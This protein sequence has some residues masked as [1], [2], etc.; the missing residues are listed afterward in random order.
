MGENV[1]GMG[2]KGVDLNTM[3]CLVPDFA[4]CLQKTREVE[5]FIWWRLAT[6]DGES[7]SDLQESSING[8]VMEALKE[9]FKENKDLEV[10]VIPFYVKNLLPITPEAHNSGCHTLA[11]A[12][13]WAE[14]QDHLPATEVS[15]PLQ[16]ISREYL[17]EAGRMASLSSV[18]A[19]VCF[20]TDHAATRAMLCPGFDRWSVEVFL[21][22]FKLQF[23]LIGTDEGLWRDSRDPVQLAFS[24]WLLASPKKRLAQRRRFLRTVFKFTDL[25]VGK[26]RLLDG[27]Q[28]KNNANQIVLCCAEIGIALPTTQRFLQLYGIQGKDAYNVARRCLRRSQPHR[29]PLYLPCAKQGAVLVQICKFLTNRAL[30]GTYTTTTLIEAFMWASLTSVQIVRV[31]PVLGYEGFWITWLE[32]RMQGYLRALVNYCGADDTCSAKNNVMGAKS[33]YVAV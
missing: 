33:D 12:L 24:D 2:K 17:L 3:T 10:G 5:R 31:G 29:S 25:P 22:H 23:S 11:E 15:S 16:A 6:S 13:R 21:R 18:G 1:A 9:F 32:K 30:D 7:F 26:H 14:T 4:Q 8:I 20:G 19:R 27:E 28:A